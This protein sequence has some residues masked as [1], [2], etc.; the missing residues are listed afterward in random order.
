VRSVPNDMAWSNS[1]TAVSAATEGFAL[2]CAGFGFLFAPFF[3][4]LSLRSS[5]VLL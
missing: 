5:N 4:P 1:T 3:K 2:V